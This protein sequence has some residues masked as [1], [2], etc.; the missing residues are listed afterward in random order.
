MGFFI[1]DI[2]AE[3]RTAYFGTPELGSDALKATHAILAALWEHSADL[4]AR[5]DHPMIGRSFLV[6]T[7]I[8]GGG[9]IA[10]PEQCRISLIRKLR[11]GEDPDVA[12][13]E[14][15]AVVRGAVTDPDI[16]LAFTYP[17]GRDHA[18]GG[19]AAEVDPA[20]EAVSLLAE[21]ARSIRP[22]RGRIAGAPFWSEASFLVARG[23]PA[24]YF[25]PGDIRICH[26]LEERVAVGEYLDGIAILA[27]FI[28]RYCGGMDER[29][30]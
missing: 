7:A 19:M 16:R 18:V 28:A 15:E 21:V 20:G 23:I 3:G 11:P 9:L 5:G 29:K 8:E 1:A 10:V 14:L 27:E 22:D 6:V 17:A 12:R 25:A 4:A 2:V 26:S 13:A 30:S 24:V